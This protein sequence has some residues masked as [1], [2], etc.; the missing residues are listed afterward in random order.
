[1]FLLTEIQRL[2]KMYDDLEPASLEQILSEKD[3]E[4][5]KRKCSY[6]YKLPKITRN[7]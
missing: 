7:D 4:I 3:I 1:M 6:L 5:I 2:N